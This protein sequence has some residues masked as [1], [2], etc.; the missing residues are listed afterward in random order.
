MTEAGSQHALGQACALLAAVTWAAALILYRRCGQ[1]V[2]PMALNLFKNCVGLV[3]LGLTLLVVAGR[4]A[5][6]ADVHAEDLR[7]LIISGA[8]GIAMADTIFFYSLNLIGVGLLAIV[9]CL[10]TPFVILFSWLL[11]EERLAAHHWLGIAL[12][13]GAVLLSSRHGAGRT[14]LARGVAGVVLGALSMGLMALGIVVAKPA[15]ERYPLVWATL[16]RLAAGTA[17]LAPLVFVLGHRASVAVAFRPSSLWR[18]SVPASVLST[19]LCL[20]FWIAG[21]KYTWASVAAVLN[22][23]STIFALL[24]ASVFLGE[25]LTVRKLAAAAV[26]FAGVAL[27]VAGS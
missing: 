19:Y 16:L 2:T 26:A 6:P 4:G 12:V 25:P 21:F 20:L 13:L 18:L 5:W 27:V 23:T 10:Y 22:Q 15:L 24:L 8:I 9:E 3:C 7:L 17:I 11:L 1:S 14:T